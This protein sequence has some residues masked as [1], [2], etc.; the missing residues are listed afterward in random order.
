MVKAAKVDRTGILGVLHD[1]KM[2]QR[3]TGGSSFSK[4]TQQTLKATKPS[5]FYVDSYVGFGSAPGSFSTAGMG[6]IPAKGYGEALK[7]SAH[8]LHAKHHRYAKHFFGKPHRKVAVQPYVDRRK[9][10][11]NLKKDLNKIFE[12][13]GDFKA[14]TARPLLDSKALKGIKGGYV[15][16]SEYS[17]GFGGAPR[18]ANSSGLE[19][20]PVKGHGEARAARSD[21][22]KKV[23]QHERKLLGKK[24]KTH[25]PEIEGKA[26]AL[27]KKSNSAPKKAAGPS[28]GIYYPS[29]FSGN[30]DPTLVSLNRH[31]G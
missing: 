17:G 16:D 30:S 6:T 20:V 12:P 15:P 11:A 8:K 29:P 23:A 25:F 5:D 31:S 26:L 3:I 19:T 27:G 2:F 21:S 14:L 28:L 1:S 24:R 10:V 7:G 4:E 9:V 18:L 13:I 22:H